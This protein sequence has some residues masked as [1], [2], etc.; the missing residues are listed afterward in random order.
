M[1]ILFCTF[2]PMTETNPDNLARMIRLVGEV[3]DTRNDPSQISVDQKAVARLRKIHPDTMTERRTKNGPIAWILV[4]PTTETLM[5]EFLAGRITENDL[6]N[7]TPFRTKYDA[8][9][10]CS[11]LVLPEY[12]RRGIAR[13][14]LA[15]TV[16]SIRKD[17]PIRTLFCWP[18]TSA[19]KK[20][21]AAVARD[22]ALP[23][24]L[25][26]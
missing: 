26:G 2:I 12:R 17:F 13:R 15:D 21:A 6:L 16:K 7:R 3:F 23:L 14:M 9:Y 10:L 4:F 25:R 22:A 1:T 18:F 19:G 11:A 24:R 8:M 5:E 20:L